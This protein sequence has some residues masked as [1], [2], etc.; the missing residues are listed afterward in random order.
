DPGSC[1]AVV[2]WTAPT[3]SDNC[4]V[5]LSSSHNSGDV[6]LVGT[7]TVTYTATD[8]AGNTATC[9]FN[10]TVVDTELP[11]ITCPADLTDVSA[12]AGSCDATGVNLG[13][14]VVADNCIDFTYTNDA[15]A[16]FPVGTTV[17]TWTV[18]D[19]SNNTATCTQ[20]V[21]VVDT[22]LPTITGRAD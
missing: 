15:P 3:A 8:G 1:D 14:P 10:V 20:N 6:F 22:E 19:A 16:S 11:T 9:S 4:S 17:V 2:E 13:A 21:T 5:L 7:T 18:T 12:D